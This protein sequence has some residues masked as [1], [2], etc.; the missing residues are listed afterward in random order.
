MGV[1]WVKVG[2]RV[3]LAVV[4]VVVAISIAIDTLGCAYQKCASFSIGIDLVGWVSPRLYLPKGGRACAF[5]YSFFVIF[6][7][8]F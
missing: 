6:E 3:V 7:G 4:V 8:G 2:S 1:V 5:V